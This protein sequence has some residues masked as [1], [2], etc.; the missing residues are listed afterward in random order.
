MEQDSRKPTYKI[1]VGLEY[2][3]ESDDTPTLSLKGEQIVAD[4]IIKLAKRFGIPVVEE[5]A[6]ADAL[7]HHEIDQEIPEELYHAVAVV[8]HTLENE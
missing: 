3:G 5:D 6:L 4:E 8:L 7:Q 1:A 2:S